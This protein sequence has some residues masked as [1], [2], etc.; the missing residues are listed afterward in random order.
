MANNDSVQKKLGKVRAPR[1]H[2]TYD[3][4]VGDAIET[5]EIPFVVGVLG[6][7][8]GDST[9]EQPRLKDKKFVEIDLDT[10]D[11]VMSGLAPRA[12]FRVKNELSEKGGEFAVDLA[13]DA[14][15]DFRPESVANQIEPLKQLV[16]AR[17]RLAD[18]RNKISANEKLED[19]LDEVLKNTEQVKN[20][21]GN[22]IS[23]DGK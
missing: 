16:A 12:T 11:E 7:F 13:F 9:L 14:I 23:D 21:A 1:V 20:M 17:D 10:F 3:V 18:L 8:S 15:D 4:E 5:K 2:L 19:L 6:E 22:N